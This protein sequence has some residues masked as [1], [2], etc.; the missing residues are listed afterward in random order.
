M[1]TT[2]TLDPDVEHLVREKARESRQSFKEALNDAI[3]QGLRDEP[4]GSAAKGFRIKARPMR[5]KSGIDPAR[6]GEVAD[7]LELNAFMAVTR[8]LRR[9]KSRRK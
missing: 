1:R 2:V 3:R 5:L 9:S 4:S 8:Q 6:L 7:D